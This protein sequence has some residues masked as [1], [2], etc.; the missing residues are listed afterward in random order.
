[1]VA[2]D[3]AETTGVAEGEGEGEGEAS[4]SKR[5]ANY[6]TFPRGNDAAMA[7]WEKL[8]EE[9][10]AQNKTPRQVVFELL[11]ARYG[12]DV[13]VI[14]TRA[15]RKKYAT[16]EER[17]AAQKAQRDTKNA[18]IKAFLEQHAAEFDALMKQKAVE[19]S[20]GGASA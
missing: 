2:T 13:P 11:S 9:A 6:V 12:T 10:Q 19:L 4:E 20:A 3:A 15:P 17:K 1:M 18:A 5:A 14:G 8:E 7:I 16:E